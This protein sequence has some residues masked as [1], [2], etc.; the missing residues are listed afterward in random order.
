M[1][2]IGGRLDGTALLAMEPGD[3]LLWLQR[4][5]DD[6]DPLG[7]F[8]DWGNR[9]IAGVVDSLATALQAEASLQEPTLEERPLMAALLGTHAPS[10]TMVLSLQGDLAFPVSGV[11]EIQA[12]F[13]IHVL[14]APKLVAG[15]VAGPNEPGDDEDRA[16]A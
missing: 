15:I 2:R 10:D 12:P 11:P 9:L 14:L 5:D 13:S 3:A 8:V 7:R 16:S 1:Q 4:G 6:S